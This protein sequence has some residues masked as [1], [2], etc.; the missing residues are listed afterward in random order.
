MSL[1]LLWIK[2]SLYNYAAKVNKIFQLYKFYYKKSIIGLF[3]NE[4]YGYG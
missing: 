4:Y 1:L 3:Y 2:H